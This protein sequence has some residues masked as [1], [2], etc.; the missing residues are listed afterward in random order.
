MRLSNDQKNAL[1]LWLAEEVREAKV[2]KWGFYAGRE[3]I[4]ALSA[5]VREKLDKISDR[6]GVGALVSEAASRYII[7]SVDD[8]L[9]EA[10]ARLA[11]IGGLDDSISLAKGI[12]NFLSDYPKDFILAVRA[13]QS[14]T[15][16]TRSLQLEIP[17]TDRFGLI[18]SSVLRNRYSLECTNLRFS[19]WVWRFNRVEVRDFADK[20]LYFYFR[21]T[22]GMISSFGSRL[23]GE[24]SDEIRAFYGAALAHDLLEGY[25]D[26]NWGPNPLLL[27]INTAQKEVE[28]TS[29]YDSDLIDATYLE[30][31][32][33]LQ[34]RYLKETTFHNALG[35]ITDF[36]RCNQP[37]LK[38]AAIWLLRSRMSAKGM[39]QVLETTIALEVLLGDRQLSDKVGLTRL[40]SNRCAYALAASTK[41]RDEIQEFFERFYGLRSK[42]V[43]T[44]R[45]D[46]TDENE[47][48]VRQGLALLQRLL[49]FEQT[50][51]IASHDC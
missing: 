1:L 14:F 17:L 30:R 38:T 28:H 36:F 13:P 22:G 49:V 29:N 18:S 5:E 20:H 3:N 42:I 24:F 16:A 26:R 40:M 51:G 15:D 35:P 6:G 45:F 34:S 25:Y 10:P 4:D 47:G 23:F 21:V 12:A 31:G 43:H 9:P 32:G 46:E 27:A 39:D 37:R 19:D 41:D 44:G 11:D 2:S 7:K 50:L 8:D 48:L 33:A